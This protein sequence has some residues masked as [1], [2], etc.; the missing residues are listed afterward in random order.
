MKT[1][2]ITLLMLVAALGWSLNVS[3]KDIYANSTSGDDTKDGSTAENAV[4]TI[5]QA[6]TLA[7][8][9]DVIHLNGTFTFEEQPLS[10]EKALTILSDGGK[11]V[12]DGTNN[13]QIL[14]LKAS[15][16]L[17]NLK[18][19]KGYSGDQGG[20]INIPLG[21]DRDVKIQDCLFIG[22]N[23]DGRAGAIWAQTYGNADKL[24]IER[25]A[26][27]SNTSLSHG[28]AIAYIAEGGS[29][30]HAVL[31]INNTTFAQ[32]TNAAGGG[33][34]LFVDGG[35]TGYA[36]F[37]F[38]NITLSGNTGG[39]NGGN[40][41]GIRFIGKDMTV[42]I[43]NSII[44]GNTASD[45]LFYDI[46]FTDN[47]TAL[48]IINSIVGYVVNNGAVVDASSFTVVGSDVN[49][50]HEADTESV[51]GLGEL[52]T[53][54]Y[55]PLTSASKA[56]DY[57][58]MQNIT[59]DLYVDQIGNLRSS[60]SRCS[61][62]AVEFFSFTPNGISEQKI[63]NLKLSTVK[64]AISIEVPTARVK[65]Y[66][67]LGKLI[68]DSKVI[69]SKIVSVAAGVYIVNIESNTKVINQKVVVR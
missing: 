44:E 40:C 5:T 38:N 61:A 56:F 33:A 46:S 62:G 67:L 26:F 1:K 50:M 32:N 58:R 51:A 27:I 9:G 59:S 43:K 11:A 22:N 30:N 13:S 31:T 45:G 19:T 69:G 12:L 25:C 37:N 63:D 64:N 65:V 8:D 39:D 21:L 52:T 55:F 16:T 18:I 23:T 4:Q 53:G 48:S 15:V 34:T 7:T 14:I 54:Y 60:D 20:A 68:N 24:T 47:P 10:V 28:G 57:G 29:T 41:P 17:K 6:Y 36:T 49:D 66:N 3:A 42:N 2:K 35:A